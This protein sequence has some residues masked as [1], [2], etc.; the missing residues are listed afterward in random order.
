MTILLVILATIG[1]HRIWHYEDI[2][3]PLRS[4]L[5][6]KFLIDPTITPLWIG[7]ILT[8]MGAI[9]YPLTEISLTVLATYPFLRGAVWMYQKFDPK[10][11]I[12]ATPAEPGCSS[13][14]QKHKEM[15]DLQASLRKFSKR[16]VLI[17]ADPS[18][19]RALADTHPG[20]LIV[21]LGFTNTQADF[22][23]TSNM[24]Y[25]PVVDDSVDIT[26][27]NLMTLLLNGGNATIVTVNKVHELFWRTVVDRIG[28]LKAMAWIHVSHAVHTAVS[29]PAH[30][31]LI[32][33]DEPLDT[34]IATTQ[35]LA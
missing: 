10:P 32:A 12:A 19:A 17:G 4:S 25:R 24:M 21:I 28:G 13:C 33:P 22:P 7:A 20:W 9:K 31:R 8:G 3:A 11:A 27:N 6:A 16:V 26:L 14:E 23:L 18:K 2:F 1:C 35:P 15:Q 34:V 30:H 29:L 5:G